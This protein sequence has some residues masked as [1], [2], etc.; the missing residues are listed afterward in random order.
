MSRYAIDIFWSDEDAGYI[1][2]VPELPGCSAWG[3][4][5]ADAAREVQ[6]AVAAWVQAARAADKAI[7]QLYMAM[8][9]TQN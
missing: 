8:K 5:E 6:D 9:P 2:E 1:A 4:S 7:P 3:A